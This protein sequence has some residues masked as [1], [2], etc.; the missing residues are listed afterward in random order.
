MKKEMK[1]VVCLRLKKET[2]KLTAD[3]FKLSELSSCQ[4][5]LYKRH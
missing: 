3:L 5:Q 4:P 1:L 2:S